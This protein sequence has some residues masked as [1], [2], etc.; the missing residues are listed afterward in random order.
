MPNLEHVHWTDQRALRQRGLDR[1]LRVAGEQ[2]GESAKAKDHHHRRI[3]DVVAGKGSAAIDV[4]R[5]D[6]LERR[7]RIEMQALAGL[8]QHQVALRF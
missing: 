7:G 8:R 2:G 4:G 5:I 1:R 6:H 3:V